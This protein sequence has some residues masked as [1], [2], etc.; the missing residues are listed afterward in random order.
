MSDN[1]KIKQELDKLENYREYQPKKQI[2]T[3]GGVVSVN[4]VASVLGST[5][6]AGESKK[7]NTE[8][9]NKLLNNCFNAGANKENKIQFLLMCKNSGDVG[10]ILMTYVLNLFKPHGDS[11]YDFCLYT[12]DQMAFYTSM[13]LHLL[14]GKNVESTTIYSNNTLKEDTNELDSQGD[15]KVE[16]ESP[17]VK[18]DLFNILRTPKKELSPKQRCINSLENIKKNFTVLL[19]LIKKEMKMEMDKDLKTSLNNLLESY[20]SSI[21]IVLNM[22][23]SKKIFNGLEIDEK[24][25]D[26]IRFIIDRLER[27][28]TD[29]TDDLPINIDDVKRVLP[30]INGVFNGLNYT[31]HNILEYTEFIKNYNMIK[32]KVNT[33]IEKTVFIKRKFV[34]DYLK[35]R[36]IVI[37]ENNVEELLFETKELAIIKN[38]LSYTTNMI[39]NT[40]NTNYMVNNI[41]LNEMNTLIRSD[42]A[43]QIAVVPTLEDPV[44][45]TR[46]KKNITNI[47]ENNRIIIEKIIKITNFFNVFIESNNI[48]SD[49]YKTEVTGEKRSG[50]DVKIIATPLSWLMNQPEVGYDKDITRKHIEEISEIYQNYLDVIKNENEKR[51]R[52]EEDLNILSSQDFE[53]GVNGGFQ[54][55]KKQKRTR[56]RNMNKKKRKTQNKR[57]NSK[58]LSKKNKKQSRRKVK[59]TK[60]HRKTR[61][62]KVNKKN[63]KK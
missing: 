41:F 5:I 35:N 61:K 53:A 32:D 54:G 20:S 29:D 33:T 6:R 44:E 34:D 46:M 24:L 43:S 49:F 42:K 7:N 36:K 19:E 51:K 8:F 26:S 16:N 50:I 37:N 13:I 10:Q 59:Q 47:N 56:K 23:I 45:V 48:N 38:L 12:E 28:L 62:N 30:L 25:E 9:T 17:N 39:N 60:K 11:Q 27:S 21:K 15:N 31:A 18:Y 3:D 2:Y 58:R 1:E 57:K 40:E 52:E 14:F 55:G 22:E 4:S 63:G